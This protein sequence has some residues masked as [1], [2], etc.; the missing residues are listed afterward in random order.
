MSI[1][2]KIISNIPAEQII[3][4]DSPANPMFAANG[5]FLI[6]RL[7]DG[8]AANGSIYYSNTQSALAYKDGAGNISVFDMTGIP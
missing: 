4:N 6:A 2:D 3:D 7:S 5:A 8:D 1:T